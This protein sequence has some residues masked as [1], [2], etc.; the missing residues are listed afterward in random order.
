MQIAT[1]NL[2]ILSLGE[3]PRRRIR[4]TVEVNGGRGDMQRHKGKPTA[5]AAHG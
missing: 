5:D 3:A 4:L 1:M 2:F